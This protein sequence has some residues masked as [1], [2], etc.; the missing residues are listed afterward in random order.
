MSNV[1]FRKGEMR[2]LADFFELQSA[3]VVIPSVTSC[4]P[5]CEVTR[6]PALFPP[7]EY[8]AARGLRLEAD[9]AVANFLRTPHQRQRRRSS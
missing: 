1:Q 4:N 9:R 6:F 7:R 2:A 5:P 8:L 3:N